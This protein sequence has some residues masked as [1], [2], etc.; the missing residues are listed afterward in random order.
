MSTVRWRLAQF[1]GD[2]IA[3]IDRIYVVKHYRKRRVARTT[4][5][6][7]LV[8]MLDTR[9]KPGWAGLAVNPAVAFVSAVLPQEVRLKPFYDL[10]V[11][12]GFIARRQFAADPTGQWE[13]PGA[14]DPATG[15]PPAPRNY[16]EVSLP[17]DAVQP[18]LEK[19]RAAQEGMRP[20][21]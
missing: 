13:Q 15:S 20:R 6:N 5:L 9:F 8:D 11:G 4:I 19:A 14:L 18:L 16:V 12:M 2:T 17:F 7:A 21:A 1:G 3:L 10:L